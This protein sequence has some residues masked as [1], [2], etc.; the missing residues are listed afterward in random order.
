MDTAEKMGKKLVTGPIHSSD[1]FYHEADAN[2]VVRNMV[3]TEGLL[4][5]EMESFAL[6]HNADVLGKKAACLLT[7][8]DSLVTGE[9]LDADTRATAFAEMVELALEAAIAV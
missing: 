4:C 5:V 2:A 7:I 8:S 6:F 3:D 9:E 1:A